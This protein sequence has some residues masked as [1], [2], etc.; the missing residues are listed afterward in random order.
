MGDLREAVAEGGRDALPSS[1]PCPAPGRRRA[2][3]LF[4][5]SLCFD[6]DFHVARLS[7]FEQAVPEL[8]VG[9]PQTAE[10]GAAEREG[11]TVSL[12]G[13]TGE[14]GVGAAVCSRPR[15]KEGGLTPTP[16]GG[17]ALRTRAR[18]PLGRASLGEVNRTGEGKMARWTA[19]D[20]GPPGPRGQGSMSTWGTRAHEQRRF[21][22]LCTQRLR[23]G[24]CSALGTARL[25]SVRCPA[26]R[27][28]PRR[29]LP[30]THGP[31]RQEGHAAW[32]TCRLGGS[33]LFFFFFELLSVL[34]Y[35]GLL[36]PSAG[37]LRP[38]SLSAAPDANSA[39]GN[40]FKVA[41]APMKD[42]SKAP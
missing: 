7:C 31:P 14:A 42:T 24:H 18:R 35:L 5:P 2:S 16:Q 37:H 22:I 20:R 13:P 15:T 4:Y 41:P 9:S 8:G 33:P 40:A 21:S 34:S 17:P 26:P 27:S 30:R 23:I 39:G 19:G 29:T 38:R 25:R 3:L 28:A 36:N 1:A 32:P 12:R 11:R 10:P 6:F